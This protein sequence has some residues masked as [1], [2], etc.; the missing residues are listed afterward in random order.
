MEWTF[1]YYFSYW[2]LEICKDGNVSDHKMK[3]N[4]SAPSEYG[5]NTR[6]NTDVFY[7]ISDFKSSLLVY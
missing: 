6:L 3:Y 5:L 4:A 1:N 7:D 2:G